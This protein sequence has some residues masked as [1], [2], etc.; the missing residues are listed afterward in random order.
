MIPVRAAQA[1]AAEA[2]AAAAV[3]APRE[4]ILTGNQYFYKLIL[5]NL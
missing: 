5:I 2:A 1:L 4:G 3:P